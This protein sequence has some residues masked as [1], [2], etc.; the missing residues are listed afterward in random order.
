MKI[1][2]MGTSEFAVPILQALHEHFEIVG[3]LTQPDRPKGRRRKR[4]P[5][6]IKIEAEKLGLHVHQPQNLSQA[7]EDYRFPVD[8]IVTAAY[9]QKVP[10]ALLDHPRFE[11]LNVHASLLPKYRGAAPITRAIEEGAQETG[12]SIMRMVGKMDAGPI[13]KQTSLPLS[14]KETKGMLEKRLSQLG[15]Q[16]LLW[17]INAIAKESLKPESQSEKEATYAHKVGKK[18]TLLSFDEPASTIE[19]KIRAHN[20]TPGAYFLYNDQPFK[21]F[22]AKIVEGSNAPAGQVITRLKNE[23]HIQ[24]EMGALSLLEVQAAGKKRMDIASYLNGAGRNAFQKGE[25]IASNREK[26]VN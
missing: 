19:R 25:T 14:G 18:D 20:P 13:F 23:V 7:F 22:S 8:F 26:S 2:F 24:T 1:L 9:G 21:V 12:V 6:P 11:A 16:S 3:V 17:T 10:R 4:E 5:S 15:A